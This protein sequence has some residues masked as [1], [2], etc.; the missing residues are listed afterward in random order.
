MPARI[1]TRPSPGTAPTAPGEDRL[2][3]EGW[4]HPA[5]AVAAPDAF[6]VAGGQAGLPARGTLDA[7]RATEQVLQGLPLQR[8]PYTHYE[9][10]VHRRVGE[11]AQALRR[12][13]AVAA[14]GQGP[15]PELQR[16]F[17]TSKVTIAMVASC[18]AHEEIQ[19]LVSE[20]GSRTA[21]H[22]VVT[23]GGK[24]V[25]DREASR[26]VLGKVQLRAERAVFCAVPYKRRIPVLHAPPWAPGREVDVPSG[27]TVRAGRLVDVDAEGRWTIELTTAS[28]RKTRRK[29][30]AHQVLLFNNPHEFNL[31]GGGFSEVT[32]DVD[33]D[34]EFRRFLDGALRLA[35]PT[36]EAAGP[37]VDDQVAAQRT[38]L[39]ALVRYVAAALE[40]PST[41]QWGPGTIPPNDSRCIRFNAL[42]ASAERTYGG[43]FPFGQLLEIRAGMCRH[44]AIALQAVLQ[45]VGIDSRLTSGS[46]FTAEGV[47]RGPHVWLEVTLADGQRYLSDPQWGDAFLPL[48]Q[49]YEQDARR[50]EKVQKTM[51]YDGNLIF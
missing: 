22:F 32:L 34:A 15:L 48:K 46:A 1:V 25:E 50:Q 29:M 11:L 38:V 37:R 8:D 2:P 43:S 51:H 41:A 16:R 49:T 36:L 21:R 26:A 12:A 31:R 45:V 40:Y 5:P 17:P 35:R 47:F 14:S 44:R 33:S 3:T 24:L 27:P 7:A 20:K 28:G 39:E 23:P 18:F 9:E 19:Y 13:A 30:D 6:D 10:K 4:G 42:Q